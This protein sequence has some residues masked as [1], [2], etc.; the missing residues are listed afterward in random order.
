MTSGMVQ[1]LAETDMVEGR[2]V[3]PTPNDL[4]SLLAKQKDS[5][6][7]QCRSGR[8]R[9]VEQK[10]VGCMEG[11]VWPTQNMRGERTGFLGPIQSKS[12][13]GGSNDT[14]GG[15]C[16]FGEPGP[17]RNKRKWKERRKDRRRSVGEL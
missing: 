1:R 14:T 16:A 13:R 2:S 3:R 6:P 12:L 4:L 7:F 11:A 15:M 10:R 5:G 8:W 17:A 9:K